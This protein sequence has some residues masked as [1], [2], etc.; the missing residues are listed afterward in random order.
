MAGARPLILITNDDGIESP[1]LWALAAAFAGRG[2]LLIVAPREQQSGAGRSMPASSSGRLLPVDAVARGLPPGSRAYAADAMPAQAVQF[3]VF[4]LAERPLSLVL[5]GINYGENVGNGVTISGTVGAALEAASFGIP[6]LAVSQQTAPA[7]HDSHSPLV[8]FRAAALFARYFGEWL[9]D[10]ELPGDGVA[11]KLDLPRGATAQTPWRVTRV[12]RR[13]VYMPRAPRDHKPEAGARIGYG[14]AD[15]I[16]LAEPDSDT[17]ALHTAG[18]VSVTPLS[19]DLTARIALPAFE[20]QLRAELRADLPDE[21]AEQP[22]ES[23]AEADAGT[24]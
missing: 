23:P 19:L 13:R 16:H 24:D 22:A 9:L 21:P 7:L 3:A 14:Y 15:D 4:V 5:S 10:G 12:S 6:A 20:A 17:H 11:L 2:E 18:E 8:D 1:G